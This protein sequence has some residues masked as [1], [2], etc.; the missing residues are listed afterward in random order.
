MIMA[1]VASLPPPVRLIAGLVMGCAGEGWTGVIGIMG[2]GC[3]VGCAAGCAAGVIGT[4]CVVGCVIGCVG[5]GCA[6]GV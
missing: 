4:D 5:E 6:A 3:V 1:M 2:T